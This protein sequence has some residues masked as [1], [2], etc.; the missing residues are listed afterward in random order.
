MKGETVKDKVCLRGPTGCT[1]DFEFFSVIEILNQKGSAFQ[2]VLGLTPDP[3]G[4]RKSYPQHL[5]DSGLIPKHLV[6]LYHYQSW[7]NI[8][9]GGY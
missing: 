5:K 6:S 9:F 7:S 8:T 4:A 1:P 3:S 2:G